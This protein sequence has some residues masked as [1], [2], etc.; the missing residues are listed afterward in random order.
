MSPTAPSLQGRFGLTAAEAAVAVTLAQGRAV[1]DLAGRLGV[2][3]NTVRTHIKI[4]FV[5]TGINRQ[6]QLVA[7]VLRRVATLMQG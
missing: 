2:T 4:I 3:L 6:A 7:S 1:E 5:K